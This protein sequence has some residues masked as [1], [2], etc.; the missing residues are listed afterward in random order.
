M[1]YFLYAYSEMS[2]KEKG[3]TRFLICIRNDGVGIG[4]GVKGHCGHPS[5][6]LRVSGLEY[7]RLEIRSDD[8]GIEHERRLYAGIIEAHYVRVN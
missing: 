8:K 4:G 7:T 6:G 2:G 3:K 1:I 5:I